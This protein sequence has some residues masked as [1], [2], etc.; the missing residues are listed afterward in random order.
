[1]RSRFLP[2]IDLS[3]RAARSSAARGQATRHTP[4]AR[5][6]PQT[7]VGRFLG[8]L[9]HSLVAPSPK[10]QL[11]R[12]GLES[13]FATHSPAAPCGPSW[14]GVSTVTGTKPRAR[15]IGL[16]RCESSK[17]ATS[18]LGTQAIRFALLARWRQVNTLEATHETYC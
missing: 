9:R 7:R 14:T 15:F 8:R 1:M 10:T 18:C 5:R 3:H 16:S 11:R 17:K 13:Q 12:S 6:E 4:I 2:S